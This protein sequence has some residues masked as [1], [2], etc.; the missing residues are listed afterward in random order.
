M[1]GPAGHFFPVSAA[2]N[3]LPLAEFYKE[4]ATALGTL[5]SESFDSSPLTF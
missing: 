3:A 2:G 1:C 5:D 4:D